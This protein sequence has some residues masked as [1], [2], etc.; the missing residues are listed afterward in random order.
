MA[1][2]VG[3]SHPDLFAGVVCMAGRPKQFS[4]RY[5]RNSQYL[6]TY[7]VDGELDGDAMAALRNV[8]Q[9]M[10][11]RGFPTLMTMYKGR[12]QEWYPGELPAI[13]KW[14]DRKKR[15][16]PY[17]ELGRGGVG[18]LNGQEFYSMRP[19]DDRFYWLSGSGL[20]SRHNND[21]HQYNP[22]MGPAFIQGKGSDKNQF[23]LNV[24]GFKRLVLWLS[25]SMID[26]EKPLT[27]YSENGKNGARPDEGP[28]QHYRRCWKAFWQAL[29]AITPMCRLNWCRD[30]RTRNKNIRPR[31]PN[32]AKPQPVKV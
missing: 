7:F 19:T 31:T 30:P 9:D 15:V 17:P 32:A 25:P 27:I 10:M 12:G 14:M 24:N 26:F 22:K 20:N 1:L 11:P 29:V 8:L 18:G 3:Y 21:P 13:F 16:F 23:N 4:M 6:P 28:A 2:D 5:W